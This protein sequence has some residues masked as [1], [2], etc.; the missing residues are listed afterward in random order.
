M[1]SLCRRG[2][3]LED[4]KGQPVRALYSAKANVGSF[5]WLHHANLCGSWHARRGRGRHKSH[6]S[7][8]SLAEN[9]PPHNISAPG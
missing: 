4:G 6:L 9:N 7:C 3:G 1:F 5:S 8:H 2:D